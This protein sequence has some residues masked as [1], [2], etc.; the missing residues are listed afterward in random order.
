MV[1]AMDVNLDGERALFKLSQEGFNH[2]LTIR[3]LNN[4]V[5]FYLPLV[6]TVNECNE[7]CDNFEKLIQLVEV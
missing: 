5:Y 7:I 3:P 2:H 4:S 1:A 6:T